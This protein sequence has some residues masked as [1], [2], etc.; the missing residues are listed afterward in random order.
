MQAPRPLRARELSCPSHKAC[1]VSCRARAKKCPSPEPSETSASR[2]C[3]PCRACADLGP[4]DFGSPALFVPCPC[5]LGEQLRQTNCQREGCYSPSYK[6]GI[7]G[8]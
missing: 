4:R 7:K 2:R 3:A 1:E 5:W 6:K 8:S